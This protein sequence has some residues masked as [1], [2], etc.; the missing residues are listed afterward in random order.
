M[1]KHILFL[2]D[3]N[4]MYIGESYKQLTYLVK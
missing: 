3:N 2:F 4:S 1:F